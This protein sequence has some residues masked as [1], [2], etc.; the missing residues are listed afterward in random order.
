MFFVS[1]LTGG[2]T[3]RRLLE[4]M[5]VYVFV[6]LSIGCIRDSFHRQHAHRSP[7]Y[8]VA[9][10]SDQRM[11]DLFLQTPLPLDR[12]YARFDAEQKIRMREKTREMF[13]HAY[14]G[15]M[16][17]AFPHDELNPIKCTGRG[18]DYKD[19]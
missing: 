6:L 17:F 7:S 8:G 13:S 5:Y 2:T 3:V 1:L 19:P 15:Y 14:R 12:K 9:A 16:K 18:P 4:S 11:Y 10:L